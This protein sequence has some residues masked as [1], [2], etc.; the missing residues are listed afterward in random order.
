[1]QRRWKASNQS[2]FFFGEKW[3]ITPWKVQWELSID[4]WQYAEVAF[5]FETDWYMHTDLE[6]FP[7]FSSFKSRTFGMVILYLSV[8]S[9]ILLCQYA[10]NGVA[11]TDFREGQNKIKNE[12]G[13][14]KS[15][16]WGRASTPLCPPPQLSP[17][18]P[19]AKFLKKFGIFGQKNGIL[20]PWIFFHFAPL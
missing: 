3:L 19:D 5:L 9:F 13:K 8:Y 12:A 11:R 6:N 7:F 4:L 2:H 1:M 16:R 20:P 15:V 18:I 17:C 10:T 14:R